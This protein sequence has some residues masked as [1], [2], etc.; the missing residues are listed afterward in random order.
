MKSWNKAIVGMLAAAA[1]IAAPFATASASEGESQSAAAP[2]AQG[3]ASSDPSAASGNSAAGQAQS[4]GQGGSAAQSG[5]QAGNGNAAPSSG[6]AQQ[7]SA[8]AGKDTSGAPQQG[9]GSAQ[10]GSSSAAQS[11]TSET[12]QSPDHKAQPAPAPKI[13]QIPQVPQVQD[14]ACRGGGSWGIYGDSR[15]STYTFQKDSEGACTVYIHG[16]IFGYYNVAPY[17]DN[18]MVTHIVFDA[19]VTPAQPDLSSMFGD[20][21][22]VTKIEGLHYISGVTGGAMMF[23]GDPNLVSVDASGFD[24]SGIKDMTQMFGA[25]PNLKTVNTTGWNTSNTTNMTSMFQG[26]LKLQEVTGINDWNTSHVTSL[27]NTFSSTGLE[28]LD[29]SNWNTGKV[30]DM[31]LTFNR[32]L[33]LKSLNISNW[34]VS[35]VEAMS[36]MFSYDAQLQNIDV[37]RWNTPALQD[38][39]SLFIGDDLLTTLDLSNWSTHNVTGYVTGST[40][41]PKTLNKLILGKKTLMYPEYF[42][43]NTEPSDAGATDGNGYSGHWT[44]DDDSWASDSR[45]G[46]DESFSDMTHA[47]SFAGGTYVWQEFAEVSFESNAPSDANL[48]GTTATKRVEKADATRISIPISPSGFSSTKYNFKGWNTD[49]R[50][51]GTQYVGGQIASGFTRS[52]HSLKLYAQWELKSQP[53]T[54]QHYIIRYMANAPEGSTVT[55]TVPDDSFDVTP[56]AGVDLNNY[57]RTVAWNSDNGKKDGKPGYQ[58]TGYAFT[59]WR[60]DRGDYKPGDIIKVAP[61]T[62]VLYAQWQAFAPAPGPVPVIPPAQPNPLVTPAPRLPAARTPLPAPAPAARAAA[63]APS[64]NGAAPTATAPAAPVEQQPLQQRA[65]PKCIPEDVYRKIQA[66][67]RKNN[68]NGTQPVDLT[69]TSDDT[70]DAEA[71][72]WKLSDYNGLSRCEVEASAPSA[73]VRHFSFW[74]L[75]LFLIPLFLLLLAY[76]NGGYI[77]ARHRDFDS[78]TIKK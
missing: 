17:R 47:S 16:G 74:W 24:T 50:G 40:A 35:K 38:M 68:S 32:M 4:A 52:N 14:D 71:A 20:L 46:D 36:A 44:K 63:P 66:A 57:P 78:A 7:G 53:Q 60:S 61:G 58:I 45:G 43:Y 42:S 51:V 25:D 22:T 6:A 76:R 15:D 13:P 73:M 41:F 62:T 77:V 37:H 65:R 8:A 64:N 3:L 26:A 11:E 1:M 49:P 27:N 9:N 18:D 70:A 30:T 67:K 55:G 31:E 72:A 29:L 48:T 23:Y 2:S 75:L 12:A 21:P 28:S 10:Q 56:S 19:P 69:D 5:A 54:S 34:N 59:S 33:N 39:S